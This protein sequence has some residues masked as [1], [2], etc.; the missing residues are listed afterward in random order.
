MNLTQLKLFS[1]I[2]R[3]LSFVKVAQQNHISQPAVSVH[4]KKLEEELGKQL[5]TR[6]PHN[7]QLTPEGLV[8]LSDVKKILQLCENLK[9]RANYTQETLEGNIRIAAIHSFGMY[10]FGDFLCSFMKAY[11]KVHINLEFR[12]FDEIYTLLQKERID[13]GVV[14]YPEKRTQIETLPLGEDVLVLIVGEGHRLF[15][16]KSIKLEQINNEPFVAFSEGIPTGEAIDRILS[17]KGIS[18]D[19]RM[20]NDNVYTLK[21]AVA[22]GVG[23]SI[24]PSSTVN[25]EVLDGIL[26][27][28]K[29]RDCKLVRPLSIVKIKK[30]NLSPPVE[31][32]IDQLLEFNPLN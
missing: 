16:S 6:T 23:I 20:S 28:I 10:E 1:A 8:I 7:I 3:E 26:S 14:A 24:V 32:F 5:L 2:T 22:A 19:V 9:H 11:P 18:V 15:G 12:R 25:E 17:E 31:V 4:I 30:D 27:R 29:I 21:K 13:L